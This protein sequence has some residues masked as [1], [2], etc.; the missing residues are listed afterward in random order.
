MFCGTQ[1]WSVWLCNIP[2]WSFCSDSQ[3]KGSLDFENII[4]T[5]CYVFWFFQIQNLIQG[6]C[7]VLN[8]K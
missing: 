3:A 2:C 5:Y 1:S 6:A 7:A 8:T 4:I